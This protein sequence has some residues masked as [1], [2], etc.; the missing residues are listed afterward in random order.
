MQHIEGEKDSYLCFDFDND[1]DGIF[2]QLI[3]VT[4]HENLEEYDVS[5][6][7]AGLFQWLSA[8]IEGIETGR[9]AYSEQKDAIEFLSSNFEPAY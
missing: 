2:G 6:V 7:F 3:G 9:M 8:T 4:P 5:F 1:E